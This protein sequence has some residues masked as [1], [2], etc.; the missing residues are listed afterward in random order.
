MEKK[1]PEICLACNKLIEDKPKNPEKRFAFCTV[2]RDNKELVEFWGKH[3][4]KQG[5]LIYE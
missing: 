2:C 1:N 3:V 5:E 4:V